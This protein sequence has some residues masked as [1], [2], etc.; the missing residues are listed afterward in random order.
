[1]SRRASE[2]WGNLQSEVS[3]EQ[4]RLEKSGMLGIYTDGT[5][6]NSGYDLSV[7]LENIHAVLFTKDIPYPGK[8]DNIGLDAFASFLNSKTVSGAGIKTPWSSNGGNSG[9][10]VID[11]TDTSGA[12]SGSG[13]NSGSISSSSPLNSCQSSD[14]PTLDS[15]FLS[16]LAS[17]LTTGS[18]NGSTAT[19]DDGS[20]GYMGSGSSG[21]AGNGN[22]ANGSSG[23]GS[24]GD[25]IDSFPCTGFF[26]IQIGMDTGNGYLL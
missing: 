14:I 20:S 2:L 22:G 12:S 6:K 3:Q 15:S 25:V 18:S 17:T 26:C 7:D 9:P 13:G 19:T 21:N 10:R 5:L 8:A 1:M 4:N 11:N 16:D 24:G 23:G